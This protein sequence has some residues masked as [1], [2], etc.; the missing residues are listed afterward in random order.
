MRRPAGIVRLAAT[1]LIA[2]SPAGAATCEGQRR[3]GAGRAA[4]QH[5]GA[6]VEPDAAPEPDAAEAGA[7]ARIRLSN[8][9][10]E[11]TVT[12]GRV[13]LGKQRSG[14]RLEAASNR[15][16]A[17]P[18]ALVGAVPAGREVLSDPVHLV[19]TLRAPGGQ[20]LRA[21]SHGPVTQ[22]FQAHQTSFATRKG[23]GD[24][25]ARDG[26]GGFTTSS[27]ARPFVT[28]LDVRGSARDGVVATIMT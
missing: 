1:V 28:E 10:G 21:G 14:A 8:R 27:T 2:P 20:H 3:L 4:E 19:P 9:F 23:A 25:S 24:L 16:R 6:A 13:R 7:P 12:F 5:R 22:H 26:A 18:R 15:P 17:L 11:R